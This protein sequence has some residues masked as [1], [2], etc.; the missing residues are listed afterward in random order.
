MTLRHGPGC[1]VLAVCLASLASPVLITAPASPEAFAN[2]ESSLT[3]PIRVSAAGSRLFAVNT[4]D[5]RLSVFDL[6]QPWAPTLIAEIPVG[7][8][9]VSVNPRSNDEV[10]VVNQLSDSISIVSVSRGIVVDTIRVPDEPADVVFAGT[11]RAFVT[12]SRSNRVLAINTLS[13]IQVAS[14]PVFGDSPRALAVSPDGKRVYAAFALSGNRTTLVPGVFAPP[15][16]P[17]DNPDLPPAPREGLIV[18]AL[19]PAWSRLI[20]YTM[21]DND[22]VEIDATKLTVNRNF[23]RVG[24]VNCGLA[25]QPT[26]GAIYVANTNARNLVRF[27]S[28]LRG[29]IVDSRITRI[30]PSSGTVTPFDL[31]PDID[32]S[33]LPNPAARAIA[34]AEPTAV[35]FEPGGNGLY[36]A[37]FGTDR[38]AHVDAGGNVIARIEIGP[39]P[40]AI[41]DPSSKRGPR[42]LAM[43]GS[44]PLLYVLNRIS[45][46]ITVILTGADVAVNAVDVGSFDPTPDVIRHG[47]G[48]LYDAKL[49]GNGTASCAS[50]HVDADV[51]MLAWDLGNPGGSMQTVVSATGS[52]ELHPMKGP[53]TTQTLRGLDHL[54]PVHW[55]GD[56][57]DFTAFNHAFDA[58]MG[59]TELSTDDMAAFR[60]FIN[61]IRFQ[62]N[63]NQKLDRTLPTFLEG[64]NPVLGQAIFMNDEYSSKRPGA[65][66]ASCHIT[67]GPGTNRTLISKDLLQEQQDF[68]V[69]HLRAVYRKTH[70]DKQAGAGVLTCR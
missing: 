53:M 67:P 40:G 33:I 68:K 31:N 64:G 32:Y 69:P 17:P 34:L 70:F 12:A 51:D 61:T 35:V 59:G 56:R 57:E 8:E 11:N 62:P 19:D 55:R 50:C 15:P 58:L 10:W 7:L 52:F 60:D 49:S 26:T 27:E 22:V 6:S 48:F 16:P 38:V 46:T 45:N 20:R 54:E 9:P 30:D 42:G 14:I 23:S 36:V 13:H 44:V 3:S 5:A 63:P 39:A 29:H 25:I 4:P 18:D 2:F 24:T 43:H 28:A 65:P 1:V 41:V 37:A 21:P 47:R 66:C